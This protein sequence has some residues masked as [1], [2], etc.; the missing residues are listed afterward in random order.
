MRVQC[1][2]LSNVIAF[3]T[4]VAQ[5]QKINEET[6]LKTAELASIVYLNYFG[7]EFESIFAF[8]P[9]GWS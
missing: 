4:A 1:A 9:L 6:C 5:T 7:V 2:S 3:L 8:K